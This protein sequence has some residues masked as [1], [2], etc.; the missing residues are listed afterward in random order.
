MK[1][2]FKAGVYRFLFQGFNF[3]LGL[4][5]AALSGT[6]LFGIISLMI[7]NATLFY[8]LT[9]FGAD[10]AIVWHG[11]SKKFDANKIFTFTFYTAVLQFVIFFLIAYFF[12]QYNG[13]TLLSRNSTTQYFHL[14]L[15][16]FAGLIFLDKYISLLY[17][18]HKAR[19][20]NL[21]LAAVTLVA[22][23]ILGFFQFNVF[24]K[25]VDPLAFFCVLTFLQA[26]SIIFL[27]HFIKKIKLSFFKKADIISFYR[28]SGIVF[29]TNLIQ[30][31]AYRADYWFISYFKEVDQVGIYSQANKF[32]GLLWILPNITAALLIP[33]LSQ[34]A[35][36]LKE[37]EFAGVTRIFIFWNLFII[38]FMVLVSFLIYSYF[39][40]PEYSI[41]FKPMLYMM[42]GYYF[43]SI[44]ILLA[45][46]FSAKNLLWINLVGSSIC[47]IAIAVADYILI[48]TMGITGAAWANT[49]AYSLA[50]LFTIVMFLKKSNLKAGALFIM[51][52]NDWSVITK[53][54]P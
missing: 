2:T 35:S 28:F 46:Y 4:L 29:I 39:L 36:N 13:K 1:D 10:Q 9:G 15:I 30:F 41:G 5:I 37:K 24:K 40:P 50:S 42:P 43:F 31:L 44:T 18:Q 25:N 20:C 11:A 16:Y 49:I 33:L 27:F 26:C 3:L 47:F 21:I 17:A 51:K 22:I 19:I 23:I 8:L 14:E 54:Q 45:A 12:F 48:P 34:P 32:A 52:K 38:G 53:L 7:V 6:E